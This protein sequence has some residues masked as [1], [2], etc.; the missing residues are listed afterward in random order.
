MFLYLS[1]EQYEYDL[2]GLLMSFFPGAEIEK[3]KEP[4]SHDPG[5]PAF[6][7]LFAENSGEETVILYTEEG[8]NYEER[9]PS[10]F[11]NA[12]EEKTV[13]KQ[14][15]YRVLSEATRKTLPWGTLSGIRPVKIPMKMMEEGAESAA[16][17][18]HMEDTLYVSPEKTALAMDIAVR[19]RK[20][21]STASEN[22]YSL[23]L[24]VPFCPSIC[25]YCSFSSYPLSRYQKQTDAYVDAVIKELQFLSEA[26]RTR[27]L[28]SIYFGGGTPTTLTPAQL[29]R[30]LSFITE[31][32]DLGTLKEWTV[33]AGRP[34][35][36]DTEKLKTLHTYPVSRIS[37][38]PQTMQ[39]K[40]LDLIGRRHTVEDVERAFSLAR[41][42]GFTDINM[43]LIAGLP[44]ETP[45]DVRDSLEKVLDL[46]PENVTVHSLAIKRASRLRLNMEQYRAYQMENSDAVMESV[47][48]RLEKAGLYPYYLYRQKNMAGNQENVGYARPGKEGLY[49]ILIMEEVQDIAAVG[50]GAVS[51]QVKDGRITR[52]D[53]IKDVLLY[54]E[55]VD[56]MIERKKE[57]FGT[58][59]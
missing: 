50:A 36:L 19:E 17:R 37:V 54:L 1:R 16:I 43:D 47:Q 55:G 25:L 39:Q 29:D 33:E 21:L 14:A 10:A 5:E 4:L 32:F 42:A 13:F 46:G 52:S 27:P 49:N 34:D 8:R 7:V 53:N 45:E 20:I 58:G 38:N 15:V 59:N 11:L 12:Q 51:K 48:K 31:H 22:G 35:S 30:I 3:V 6:S 24:G 26:F 57:L 56:E 9:L 23:Y 44:G 2:R 41:E 18:A 28:D 40:T